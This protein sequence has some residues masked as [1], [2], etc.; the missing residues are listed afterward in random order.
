MLTL[1][2]FTRG[3]IVRNLQNANSDE[4]D[5]AF[6]NEVIFSCERQI[7]LPYEYIIWII[8]VTIYNHRPSHWNIDIIGTFL[9]KANCCPY[10]LIARPC[11]HGG[12]VFST[13]RSSKRVRILEPHLNIKSDLH[14]IGIP[15]PKMRRWSNRLICIISIPE[16]QLLYIE[17]PKV[18]YTGTTP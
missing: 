12:G 10:A 15:I 16:R 14:G 11:E 17:T 6:L 5:F 3:V 18:K 1:K 7:I 8:Y 2:K 9:D 4:P 13:S